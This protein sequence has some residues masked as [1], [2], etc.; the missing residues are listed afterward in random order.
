LTL[1]EPISAKYTAQ[2]LYTEVSKVEL[3][4][5]SCQCERPL[6][7]ERVASANGVSRV[8]TQ[9]QLTTR[10]KKVKKKLL[11]KNAQ[12]L[13]IFRR[14]LCLCPMFFLFSRF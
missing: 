8:Y 1:T 2:F 3:E 11:A 7:T 13:C 4:N 12:F 14:G 10:D 9:S 6:A 5:I